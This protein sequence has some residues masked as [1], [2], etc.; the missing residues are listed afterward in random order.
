MAGKGIFMKKLWI[1]LLCAVLLLNLTA[2]GDSG[3]EEQESTEPLTGV[4]VTYYHTE[5]WMYK[6]V[7]ETARIPKLTA[8]ALIDILIEEEILPEG[9]QVRN[10]KVSHNLIILDL[11]AQL[12]E[13]FDSKGSTGDQ[14]ILGSI[15]NTF[16]SNDDADSLKLTAEGRFLTSGRTIYNEPMRFFE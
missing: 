4:E 9:T 13:V 6:L 8:Q 2:C 3:K 14:V 11:T 1:A 15:V 16:L 12:E 10:F 5:G 7:P